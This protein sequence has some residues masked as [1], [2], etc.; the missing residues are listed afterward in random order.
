MARKRIPSL[1][2]FMG[3]FEPEPNTGC[4]LWSGT[5]NQYG[6]GVFSMP[7]GTPKALAH[8]VAWSLLRGEITSD[9]NVLHKCDNPPCVNP[10]H[11]FLGTRKENVEDMARKG[12]GVR[13]QN[14][15]YGVHRHNRHSPRPFE[16][17]V[18][19]KRKWFYLG[20]FSTQEEAH[21]IAVAFK[22]KCYREG[23]PK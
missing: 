11:L 7:G 20:Y 6:Y 3:K 5:L 1:D 23:A 2:R 22:E 9:Q 17:R 4:W 16:A 13:S 18:C 15:L 12:R 19:F 14:V 8:R 10:D 21:V